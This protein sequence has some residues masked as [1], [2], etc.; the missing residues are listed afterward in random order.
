VGTNG[1]AQIW[2]QLHDLERF[3]T[4]NHIEFLSFCFGEPKDESQ[5]LIWSM[6]VSFIYDLVGYQFLSVSHFLSV[7]NSCHLASEEN[8]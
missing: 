5:S 6:S 4:L 2:A 1:Q 8:R 7:S 3:D